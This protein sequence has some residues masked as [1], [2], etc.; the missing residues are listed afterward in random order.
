MHDIVQDYGPVSAEQNLPNFTD[1]Q[2]AFWS[3]L[4]GEK[5]NVGPVQ[6][7]AIDP[8]KIADLLPYIWMADLIFNRHG[9]L[10]DMRPR[11]MGTKIVELY[12]ERTNENIISNTDKKGLKNTHPNNFNRLNKALT[13]MLKINKPVFGQA[14]SFSTRLSFLSIKGLMIPA[15]R[16]SKT[17]NLVVG[18]NEGI[19]RHFY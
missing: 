8:F 13:L 5:Q 9:S 14:K 12:G 3:F 4:Y 1:K 18:L 19:E 17:V 10:V 6:R 15:Y 16:N 2:L 7:A 11:L